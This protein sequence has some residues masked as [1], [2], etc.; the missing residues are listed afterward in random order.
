MLE[1]FIK[2]NLKENKNKTKK[3]LKKKAN[4]YQQNEFNL[5]NSNNNS[6]SNNPDSFVIK[7]GN[8]NN[9]LTD[10][11]NLTNRFFNFNNHQINNINSNSLNYNNFKAVINYNLNYNNFVNN[12]NI[13]NLFNN[14]LLKNFI[15][16]LKELKSKESEF[17]KLKE[18]GLKELYNINNIN[19]FI[20]NNNINNYNINSFTQIVNFPNNYYNT[21]T[22]NN[23]SI[24][25]KKIKYIES[26]Y[27]KEH[28][29]NN[30]NRNE[31]KE[32]NI[33]NFD[34]II[35]GK[36]KRT[37][38]RLKPIPQNYSSFDISKLLDKCLKI[39][40][41]KNQRIYKAIYTPLC[42]AI[43][44]N[45]GYCFIMMVKPKYVIQF[46]ETFNGKTFNKKKCNKIISVIWADYQGDDFLKISDDPL[47]SPIIFK[48]IKNDEIE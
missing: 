8:S 13:D 32:K 6:I 41:N 47:R 36:E 43:G 20:L 24:N 16:K 30:I 44:K 3:N 35:S 34:D 37:V 38:V 18:I 19:H 42:K 1:N 48:D 2:N 23:F 10:Y 29:S 27:K 26:T 22:K 15:R 28:L 9:F 33:I 31:I 40:K 12:N 25:Q 39:E 11:I 17:N 45:V 21:E 14:N 7:N 4:F 46:Y 5:I